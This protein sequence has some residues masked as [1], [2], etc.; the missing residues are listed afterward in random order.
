MEREHN[1]I[2]G[3]TGASGQLGRRVLELVAAAVDPSRVVAITRTPE[4]LGDLAPRGVESRRG[5]FA[6]PDTLDRAFAGVDRLLLISIDDVRPG[7]RP[8]LHGNA[9]AAAKRAGVRYVIYTSAIKP[10]HSPIQFLRDHGATEQIIADSGLAY[11]FLRNNFYMDVVLQNAAQALASGTIFSAAEGGATG[12]VS[13]EDC[14]RA[15]AAVLTATG[16]EGAVY[17]ITGSEAWS[18][19]AIAQA[20]G[21]VVGRT[22]A[23][24]PLTEDALR[25]GLL[26]HGLPPEVADF[27]V[28]IDRGV[29]LGAL[30]VVSHA[31]ERLTGT[32]PE[33]LP[34][35][36]RR[37]Q[38][39]LLQPPAR[40]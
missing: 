12:Y 40:A 20:L 14:A 26:D 32:K 11:T 34:E 5:D 15:A 27:V 13:R 2:I 17:D 35:F 31:V 28:G 22:I 30:D 4:K 25:Q 16:H 19:A 10:Q 3:I 21:D 29:R 18:Q 38:A 23:Y 36:L 33:T 6:E 37:H 9:V 1:E 7:V 24:V 39:D 8:T